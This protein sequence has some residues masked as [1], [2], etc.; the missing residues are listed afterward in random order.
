MNMCNAWNH[1][2]G[3]D[4][5]FG[6]DTGGWGVLPPPPARW[7]HRDD[8]FCH[9]TSCPRCGAPVYFVRHNGGS[10]WLD[11][12]GYPWPKHPCFDDTAVGLPLGEVPD[13][14]VAYEVL[15][16]V[17]AEAEVDGDTTRLR[18]NCSDNT[19]FN[20]RFRA[21]L[22]PNRVVGEIVLVEKSRH[23]RVTITMVRDEERQRLPSL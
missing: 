23:G 16:G 15:F 3:C 18:V 22:T 20:R 2:L 10:V 1:A 17:V 19:Q 11:E 7:Q 12:L 21:A 8:D 6:G 5:G 13:K 4:C 14:L 9:P